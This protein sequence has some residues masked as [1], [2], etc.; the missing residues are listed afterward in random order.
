MSGG[1]KHHGFAF[2]PARRV[3]HA[4]AQGAFASFLATA[5]IGCNSGGWIA[6]QAMIPRRA[7]PRVPTATTRSHELTSSMDGSLRSTLY[8]R[9]PALVLRKTNLLAQC[10]IFTLSVHSGRI[11][12]AII[13]KGPEVRH[14]LAKSRQ[15]R[16]FLQIVWSAE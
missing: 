10:A 4:L 9:W 8:G 12:R 14:V 5:V 1:R 15:A 7:Q 16:F 2:N 13:E 6:I 3:A 11:F